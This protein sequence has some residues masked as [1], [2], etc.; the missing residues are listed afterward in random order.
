[1][2]TAPTV[3]ESPHNHPPRCC[4]QPPGINRTK[5]CPS[6]PEHGDRPGIECPQ[7]HQE[8][9]RPHTEYCTLDPERVW[10]DVL[11]EVRPADDPPDPITCDG[12]NCGGR[13]HA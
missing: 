7:C 6:C 13:P 9:G 5:T 10:A 8:A 4:C 12:R 3:A 1:M 2:T 11:P